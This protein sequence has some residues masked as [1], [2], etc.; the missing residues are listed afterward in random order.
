MAQTVV[1]YEALQGRAGDTPF[2]TSRPV[3]VLSTDRIEIPHRIS[4]RVELTALIFGTQDK[5]VSKAVT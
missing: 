1:R 3:D 4:L 2:N 5:A